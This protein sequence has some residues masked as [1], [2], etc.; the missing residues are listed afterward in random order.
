MFKNLILITFLFFFSIAKSFSQDNLRTNFE[1]SFKKND[2]FVYRQAEMKFKQNMQGVYS[3]ILYDTTF[4]LLHVRDLNDSLYFIDFNLADYYKND[5]LE[6]DPINENDI[7]KIETYQLSF[8]KEGRF[9]ELLNWESFASVLI[10]NLKREYFAKQID[11]NTL[12]QYYLMYHKQEYVEYLLLP[13]VIELFEFVGYEFSNTDKYYTQKY[14]KN[15]FGGKDLVKDCYFEIAKDNT[16]RNSVFVKG[17]VSSNFE[18]NPV[19]QREYFLFKN[20][21]E[22]TA[23]MLETMPYIYI[24]D[25]FE[26][27]WGIINKQIIRFVSSHTIY[28]GDEKQGLDREVLLYAR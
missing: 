5:K 12:K 17:K 22:P 20:G 1:M 14:I 8:S 24:L 27:Q 3:D 6:T 26:Y 9:V 15:P 23:A 10:Q 19:L 2:R 16:Y 21:F 18:D 25:T 4:F 11:S 28:S 7:L 13:R